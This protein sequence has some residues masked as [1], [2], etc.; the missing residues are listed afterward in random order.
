MGDFRVFDKWVTHGAGKS[1]HLI[2]T[3][4]TSK[5]AQHVDKLAGS[6]ISPVCFFSLHS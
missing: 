1:S 4:L 5:M 2:A 3:S 6:I